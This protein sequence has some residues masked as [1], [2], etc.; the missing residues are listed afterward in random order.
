MESS[1]EPR[2]SNKSSGLVDW[3][4]FLPTLPNVF[5]LILFILSLVM[6]GFL[7]PITKRGFFCNDPSI[8]YPIKMDTVS[9]KWL[10]V[11]ALLIPSLVIRLLE[12]KMSKLLDKFAY[13]TSARWQR[14]SNV[15]LEVQEEE[16]ERLMST[17]N[18]SSTPKRRLVINNDDESD[19]EE[20]EQERPTPRQLNESNSD[21]AEAKS[22]TASSIGNRVSTKGTGSGE[23]VNFRSKDWKSDRKTFSDL[24][25]F[26]FGFIATMFLTGVGKTTCG[27]FRPHFMARCKPDIDC[28]L[29]KN[30][31]RYIEDFKCTDETL[32]LRD[33]SYISTSWPSGKLT[34][35]SPSSIA[36][37][38][39][40]PD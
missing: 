3:S 17:S 30:L 24:Q 10:L 34:L 20:V 23:E 36:I 31:H 27:R 25:L 29:P 22:A 19:L 6:N 39:R 35:V 12:K 11:V 32:R 15:W 33:L 14:P 37:P 8:Q 16:D 5:L 1:Q 18:E 28:N 2:I 38:L 7:Q 4:C 40:I 13:K 21:I 9:F 26:V